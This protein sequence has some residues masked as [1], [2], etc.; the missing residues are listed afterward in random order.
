M[1][2]T[3]HE[4]SWTITGTPTSGTFA[5]GDP[6]V[7]GPVTITAI[8]PL[9]VVG[10]NGVSGRISHG[11][12]INP[13]YAGPQGF[14]GGYTLS[15][16][17]IAF[18]SA[19]NVGRPGGNALSAGNPL[20]V[21]AGSS[22]V[23]S[24]S[25]T[26][27][28]V[29][30]YM[31]DMAVLTV[32]ASAPPA[33]AFRPS[34]IGTDK[35]IRWT[36]DDLDFTTLPSHTEPINAPNI[37]DVAAMF[38]RLHFIL[39]S[40]TT[41]NGWRKITPIYNHASYAAAYG[42]QMGLGLLSTLVNNP[43]F[44]GTARWNLIVRLVQIG[45]DEFAGMEA[46]R[47][48][49]DLG[50]LNTGHKG[51][52]I[53]A[54]VF[55]NDPDIKARCN[56]AVYPHSAEYRHT[57]RVTQEDVGRQVNEP[58][59]SYI[60]ADADFVNP[61][62]TVGLYEWGEQ[63]TKQRIKD[64]RYWTYTELDASSGG[65]LY[66]RSHIDT[67]LSH[68]LFARRVGARN[69]WNNP[70][71]FGYA[72]RVWEVEGGD[73]TQIM[74]NMITTPGNPFSD[75]NATKIQA[76][77][78]ACYSAWRPLG[79]GSGGTQPEPAV[80][81]PVFSPSYRVFVDSIEVSLSVSVPAA[82]T[83]RYTLDGTDPTESSTLYTGPFTLTADTQ[84]KARGFAVDYNSS[85]I[86]S[87]QFNEGHFTSDSTFTSFAVAPQTGNAIDV[88]FD[89][90]PSSSTLD[91]VVALGGIQADA[92][93]DLAAIV[94]LAT[95]GTIN[96][97]NGGAYESLTPTNYS[98]GVKYSFALVIDHDAVPAPKYSV[99]VAHSGG[100]PVTLAT[101]YAYRTG[102]EGI[103]A[104]SWFSSA[105]VNGS[106][107]IENI[108]IGEYV[109]PVEQ[110]ALPV[111]SPDA[112]P[113]YQSTGVTITCATP[114]ASIYY[115]TDGSDP[116]ATDTLYTG[117]IPIT[118]TT[119][120]KA[121][122]IKAGATDSIIAGATYT[123]NGFTAADEDF[124]SL[125]F[126]ERYESLSVT[127]D[128]TPSAL[129]LDAVISIGPGAPTGFASGAAQVRFST[130]NVIEARNAG[131]YGADAV[132]SYA[133]AT[134]YSFELTISLA[135]H[136]YSVEV[137]PAAGSPVT[138]AT[139]YAFRSDQ[140]GATMLSHLSGITIVADTT[141]TIANLV[142]TPIDTTNHPRVQIRRGTMARRLRR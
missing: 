142:V 16:G 104:I 29:R 135:A 125:N 130:G 129:A 117:A 131:A 42:R 59:G 58:T 103:A 43:L 89:V 126:G 110:V 118:T 63:H 140:S 41:G 75:S 87:A 20:V 99:T 49:F 108:Q 132:Q 74:G 46:G 66:R 83:I 22:L 111:L 97:R 65:V 106:M 4:I 67:F 139:G 90:T 24:R 116:D 141:I 101:D 136:T 17:A 68:T 73:P 55:L 5:N 76:F 6:W 86:S 37:N 98:A 70:V 47:V 12:M 119:Q 51:S 102:Q 138:L 85:V 133:A 56:E 107:L 60:Q 8:S 64:S 2:I 10:L 57:W 120:I 34:Y 7:V 11:S 100:A 35:T 54:A 72:D 113:Y 71:V 14:E 15:T 79:D 115:T 50:G 45:I 96:V 69:I 127:F 13:S 40:E 53:A 134:A 36:T 84:V 80:A 105:T 81:P 128:A 88:S 124:V 23:S 123:I 39:G 93:G 25:R 31:Q 137:T 3:R 78:H 30:P 92:Y 114:G 38:E 32:L 19:L 52:M 94:Q 82:A 27:N 9:S 109:P 122:G 91:G 21:P 95:N 61:D 44:P 28:T 26:S 112:G 18:N 48:W 121:I 33:N 1:I 62:G 77:T